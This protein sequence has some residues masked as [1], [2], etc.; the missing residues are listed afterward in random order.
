MRCLAVTL[1][2]DVDE[3]NLAPDARPALG[4]Q[5]NAEGEHDPL[6]VTSP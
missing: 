3:L 2:D 6:F 4:F 5:P 1:G